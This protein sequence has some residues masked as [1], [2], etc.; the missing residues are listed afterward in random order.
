VGSDSETKAYNVHENFK[1]FLGLHC[2]VT[3]R[4]QEP[5]LNSLTRAYNLKI[6]AKIAG[7][8]HCEMRL[9]SEKVSFK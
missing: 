3:P 9:G 5:A 1:S 8:A 4:R 7:T 6:D 2:S